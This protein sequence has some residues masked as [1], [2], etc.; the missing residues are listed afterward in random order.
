M[1]KI[2]LTGLML[3]SFG[4]QASDVVDNAEDVLVRAQT[5]L[6]SSRSDHN[7]ESDFF[8]ALA[9]ACGLPKEIVENTYINQNV[10]LKHSQFNNENKARI[11]FEG[12]PEFSMKAV[13]FFLGN[14]KLTKEEAE[15]KRILTHNVLSKKRLLETKRKK[16]INNILKSIL[17][18]G[19]SSFPTI[20]GIRSLLN[21]ENNSTLSYS[22]VAGGCVGLF[23]AVPSLIKNFA[24]WRITTVEEQQYSDWHAKLDSQKEK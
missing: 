5:F 12:Y 13:K 15:I 23:Y 2:L 1:K 21:K 18:A 17:R 14:Q 22:A 9:G 19:V 6:E 11:F 7:E 24:M 16:H 10:P 3:S 20:L 8:S 4:I